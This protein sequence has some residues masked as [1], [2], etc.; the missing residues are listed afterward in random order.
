M[1]TMDRTAKWKGVTAEIC[2]N[3]CVITIV[4]FF[5]AFF[6]YKGIGCF[7][8]ASDMLSD[9][10]VLGSSTE[11]RWQTGIDFAIGLRWLGTYCYFATATIITGAA[12]LLTKTPNKRQS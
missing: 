3:A 10:I 12:W 2:C 7:A 4:A 1:I 6:T 9:P 8:I 5:A 11:T